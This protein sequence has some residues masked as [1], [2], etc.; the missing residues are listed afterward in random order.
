MPFECWCID[1]L[2]WGKQ[3][4]VVCICAFSKCVEAGILPDSKSSTVTRWVHAELVCRYG[5]PQVV[6]T[7][8]GSEFK[9]AFAKY[10][11]EMG[12]R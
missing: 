4:L 8:R 6:R 12:I 9:V 5:S 2:K 10:M 7:D 1:L 3:L 11:R